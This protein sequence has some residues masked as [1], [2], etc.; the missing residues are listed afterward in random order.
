MR[1]RRA[2]TNGDQ[3]RRPSNGRTRTFTVTPGALSPSTAHV[4]AK[5]VNDGIAQVRFDQFHPGVAQEALKAITDLPAKAK[6]TGVI[7]DL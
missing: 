3:R 7:I 1:S 2:K 6:L 5:L 4:S